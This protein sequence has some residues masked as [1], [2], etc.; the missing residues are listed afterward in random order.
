MTL[1]TRAVTWVD[2]NDGTLTLTNNVALDGDDESAHF[3]LPPG[4]IAVGV[5]FLG[6]FDSGTIAMQGSNDNTTFAALSTAVSATSAALKGVATADLAYKRYRMIVSG[7]GGSCAL[8][9]IL[10]VRTNHG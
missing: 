4:T 1:A 2:N 9:F 7:G 8:N 5:Q 10:H 3:A 6:T